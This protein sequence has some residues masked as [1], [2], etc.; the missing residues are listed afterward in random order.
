MRYSPEYVR[1]MYATQ[2]VFIWR[3]EDQGFYQDD[4]DKNPE[5]D[6]SR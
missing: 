2:N 1:K 3:D 4:A 5:Y 6:A